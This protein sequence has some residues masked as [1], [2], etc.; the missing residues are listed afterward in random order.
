MKH[1]TAIV[2]AASVMV[3]VLAASAAIAA[4]LGILANGTDTGEIGALTVSAEPTTSTG[5]PETPPATIAVVEDTT[6]PTTGA[7]VPEPTAPIG[8]VSAYAVADAGVVT[9]VNDGS[10]LTVTAVES[11]DGWQ[12]ADIPSDRG[13]EIGFV[14]PDGSVLLF[15]A[16]LDEAGTIQTLVE[17]LRATTDGATVRSSSDDDDDRN[18]DNESEDD[19]D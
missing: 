6:P 3:V 10:T 17:D 1:R 13:I 4:N 14:G 2:T 12:T 19:D 18:G 7:T 16:Q 9:L 11:S 5:L 15:A 8:E